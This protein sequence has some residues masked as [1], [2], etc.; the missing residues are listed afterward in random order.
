M[1]YPHLPRRRLRAFHRP[2][3]TLIELLVVIAIIAVL[4]G[5]LLPAIQSV[6]SA[7]MRAQCQNHMKQMGVAFHNANAQ[8][9]KMPPLGQLRLLWR[10]G[11]HWSVWCSQFLG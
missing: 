5:L 8:M 10:P 2:A 4:I 1:E 9:G 3:F 6:R 7:A 11:V